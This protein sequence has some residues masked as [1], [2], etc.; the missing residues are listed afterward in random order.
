M[1]QQVT[2]ILKCI[3]FQNSF[4]VYIKY[5]LFMDMTIVVGLHKFNLQATI[6][7]WP[8]VGNILFRGLISGTFVWRVFIHFLLV[9]E[10]GK[11]KLSY[12]PR[13]MHALQALFCCGWL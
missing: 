11:N 6:H 8:R 12:T 7:R 10:I 4:S 2:E 3:K 13:F 1:M 5:I 9:F